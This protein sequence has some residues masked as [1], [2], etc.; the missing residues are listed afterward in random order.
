[1]KIK[2]TRLRPQSFLDFGGEL[3]VDNFAGG[4]G[5]SSGIE[6][7][8]G[9]SVDIAI[10]HSPHAVAMH[11]AN[12]P[13]TRHYIENVWD[14]DP[15]DACGGRPVGLA[16]FSP[17][18]KHFSKAKGGKPVNKQIRGLA[19]VAIRWAA[20]VRPRV[21]MLENVEEFRT[22]GPITKDGKPCPI[23]KGKT[24]RSWVGHLENLGYRVE[25]RE[26]SA[27]DFGA[28]TTRKRLFVI[29]RCDGKPIVWPTT[30]HG[31]GL[32]KFRTAAECID[33]SI[34]CPSIFDRKKPLV[35][36]TL[37]RIARGI[38]NFV[39]DDPDP[40]ILDDQLVPLVSRIGQ[41]NWSANPG[42]R[43]D[44]PLTT[45]VSKQEHILIVPH[46]IKHFGGM[47]GVR[48]DVPFPTITSSGAQNQ[49]AI[50]HLMT[51]RN[52]MVGQDARTP[53]NTIAASG[54]HHA[55][56]RTF[57]VKYFGSLVGQHQGVDE[58]L[59]TIRTRDSF[60]IVTVHGQDYY[61][62]DI[63]MRMLSPRELFNCQGFPSDYII[64]PDFNGK[65]LTKTKQTMCCGN[66]V[67]PVLS[68]ALVAANFTAE[69]MKV[70]A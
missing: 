2:A 23:N 46:I 8:L 15:R 36:N 5:A 11:E 44:E 34:P 37:K 54:L 33:W 10:N 3:I 48:G 14:V 66:S 70:A 28:P 30:T 49:L 20:A 24:F 4:G 63:G 64:D 25:A 58:P 40:F 52:N 9:R 62:V 32:Q 68:H 13:K 29:A 43:V 50:T 38:Q 21:I 47:T 55:E 22:W 17:D 26:L 45:I 59:H 35:E 57:L 56:V 42:R 67:S 6:K 12:H 16:W 1:M 18:C 53:L 41:T 61:I 39:I 27:C 7:A 31:P 69:P 19:W 51:M 60:A 65:P